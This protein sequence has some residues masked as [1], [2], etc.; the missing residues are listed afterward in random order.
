[1]T[2]VDVPTYAQA[3]EWEVDPA[4]YLLDWK[5]GAN[6]DNVRIDISTSGYSTTP[7]DGTMTHLF[8]ISTTDARVAFMAK[9]TVHYISLWGVKDGRFSTTSKNITITSADSLY[10]DPDVI[11]IDPPS[12]FGDSWYGTQCSHTGTC[13]PADD[14]PNTLWMKSAGATASFTTT[15]NFSAF[16]ITSDASDSNDGFIAIYVGGVKYL[17]VDTHEMGTN[18][19][20]VDFGMTYAAGT[21]IMVKTV[22]PEDFHYGSGNTW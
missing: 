11:P 14:N 18:T 9:N 10:D 13:V 12:S 5:P 1:L 15:R 2:A 22:T 3:V 7:G 4:W 20:S 21:V 17:T 16:S 6:N 19:M 8:P